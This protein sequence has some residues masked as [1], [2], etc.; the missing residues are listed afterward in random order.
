MLALI[1]LQVYAH[2]DHLGRAADWKGA[3]FGEECTPRHISDLF[4]HHNEAPLRKKFSVPSECKI[5]Y[6]SAEGKTLEEATIYARA[7]LCHSAAVNSVETVNGF[8]CVTDHWIKYCDDGGKDCY[9]VF[10]VYCKNQN[11]HHDESH[12]GRHHG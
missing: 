1:A 10:L 9:K 8:E 5:F 2:S 6:G 7:N 4:D 3:T 11:K 12:H